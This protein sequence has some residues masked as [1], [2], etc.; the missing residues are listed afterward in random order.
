MSLKVFLR[1]DQLM[2]L[3]QQHQHQLEERVGDSGLL[4][5]FWQVRLERDCLELVFLQHGTHVPQP[6]V[7]A[8]ERFG[9]QLT[10]LNSLDLAGNIM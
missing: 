9:S 1:T 3:Q 6:T 2:S 8:T 5:S 10:M 7:P 4:V